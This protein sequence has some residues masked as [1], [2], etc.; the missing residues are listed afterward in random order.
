M[1]DRITDIARAPNT[2]P[3]RTCYLPFLL[4]THLFDYYNLLIPSPSSLYIIIM[5]PSIVSRLT[6]VPSMTPTPHRIV[7]I[8]NPCSAFIKASA[9]VYVIY[10]PSNDL[11][12]MAAV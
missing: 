8:I 3:T 9:A 5:T 6:I 2:T 4:C 1:H 10:R 11:S 7:C 12:S